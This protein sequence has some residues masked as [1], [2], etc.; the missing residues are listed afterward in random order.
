MCGIAG[1]T[2]FSGVSPEAET[3]VRRMIAPLASRG[4]DGEG[5]FVAP[6]VALGH[7]RLSIIDMEG[8][9]QPMV[10]RDG[11]YH[12]VYNGEIYNYVELRAALEKRGCVFKTHSD[13]EVLLEQFALDGV[14]ALQSCNGMFACAIWD[15]VTE[16]LFLARD[17]IGVKPLHYCV[18][19][20]NLIFGS[21]LKALL[22][23]PQ[24]ERRLQ[25]LSVSKFFTYGYIPCPNSIFAGIHKLPPGGY[26][27]FDRT[28]LHLDRYWDLP[29]VDQPASDRNVD[30]WAEDLLDLLRDSVK[31]RL[32]SDVPVG[33]FLSGGLDSSTIT[34]L[35]AQASEHELH[36]FSIGFDDAS[37][38]ESSYARQVAAWCG[39][40][41]HEEILTLDHAT[42]L[43]P[44]VMS[45]LDEPLGDASIVPTYFLS[46]L[47]AK[48]VKVVLGGDGADELFAGYAA[49]Q[50]HKLVQNLSF[51]PAGWR[52][53]LRHIA[54]RLPVSHRYASA[55]FLMQQFVKGLGLSPE[56]R[57]FLWLGCYGNA[58]K[59]Q[60]LS[61]PLQEGLLR[62][63]AFEDISGYIRQSGLKGDFQRLQ[64]LCLKL[65]LQDDILLKVDRASMAHSLEVRAPFLDRDVVEYAAR[66]RPADK[67]RGLTTK[68]VLKRAVRGLLP[69]EIV[70]RRKSG[71]MMP[72]ALWLQHNM[73]ELIEDLCS[74]AALAETGL[75]QPG[76]VRQLLDEHFA[77]RR[78][79]RKQI[80]PLLC[81]M[82]WRRNFAPGCSL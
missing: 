4:P 23:H 10:S 22:A 68:Y 17:R 80:Y 60:L 14:D 61:V 50:A 31:K 32:R 45:R 47:A 65:Y 54:R 39:T 35:A 34:A 77:G 63:D 30:E 33:L 26:L 79:H 12:I 28:G 82:A 36:S 56:V 24:V 27:Y 18:R 5:V 58:E 51:L 3:L 29:L 62:E 69:N 78:D 25:P 74:P 52:D 81:F 13:T 55:E 20:G 15:G 49:F 43:F 1:F 73:R 8:G 40:R 16:R 42:T 21:E 72:V 64:Y 70:H 75:F 11:R 19:H 66:I 57:F 7:R 59:K 44:E 67:L 2:Q 46:G 38:D 48:H 41:H 71:F 6:T 53:G 9:A 37:Y 76:F